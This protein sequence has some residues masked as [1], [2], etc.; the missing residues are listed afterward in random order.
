[1]IFYTLV[2]GVAAYAASVIVRFVSATIA[3]PEVGRT[4]VLTLYT[5]MRVVVM[6]VLATAVWGAGR[7][8]GIGLRPRLA[9]TIQPLAQFLAAFPANV[10]FPL[11]VLLLLAFSLNPDIWAEPAHRLRHAM[12]HPVQR[13]RRR[14]GLSQRPEGGGEKLRR[15]R[16]GLVDQ[17]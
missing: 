9:N 1:M 12:V 5:M 3:W 8:S 7:G 13:R 17:G 6:I 11:A 14:A 4:V 16:L 2:A 15:A 10:V